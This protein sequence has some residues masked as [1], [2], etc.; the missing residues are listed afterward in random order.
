MN[1]ALWFNLFNLSDFQ[2]E[3]LVSRTL[4][5]SLGSY[6]VKEILVTIGNNV[7]ILYDG[8]FLSLNLNDKNPFVFEDRAIFIDDNN[9]VW[10]GIKNED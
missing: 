4:K 6:G 10:L 7:N 2:A 1:D 8:V 3:D 5:F 9:D